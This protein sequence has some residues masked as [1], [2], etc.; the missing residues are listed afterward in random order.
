V[1]GG[2]PTPGASEQFLSAGEHSLCAGEQALS[3]GHSFLLL[4]FQKAMFPH[5]SIVFP[6]RKFQKAMARGAA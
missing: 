1:A 4:I 5:D 2:Q 6:L 3:I